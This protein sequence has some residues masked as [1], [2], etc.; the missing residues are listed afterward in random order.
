MSKIS[1]I[2]GFPEFLPDD[3]YFFDQAIQLIGSTFQKFGFERI[4]T[5]AVERTEHL[6]A[7]GIVDKE[8][9]VLQ[10]LH[11][12]AGDKAELALHFDLTVPLA[13]YVAQ[14]NGQLV[15]PF[16]RYQIQPVWRGERPQA[17]RYRQF[18]QCDIDVIGDGALSIRYDAELFAVAQEIFEKLEIGPFVFRINHRKILEA[19]LQGLQVAKEQ[20]QEV[21]KWIDQVEKVPKE[22][23]QSEIEKRIGQIGAVKLFQLLQPS[24]IAEKLQELQKEFSSELL[25][26]GVREIEE[27]FTSA[28]ALGVKK[29]NLQLDLSIARGL[30]YYTGVV[31]ETKA[32]KYPQ[33]GSI[34]SGGRYDNLVGSFLSKP[35]PGVGLSI[36][37]S[38]LLPELMKDKTKQ[39]SPITLLIAQQNPLLFSQYAKIAQEMRNAGIAT[40]LYLENKKF[41]QQIKYADRKKIPYLLFADEGELSKGKVLLKKLATSEQWELSVKEVQELLRK[42]RA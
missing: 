38:R 37:I 12:E 2:S 18:Y 26:E 8:V 20:M 29:E 24:P 22:L 32:Q 42:E 9:Y 13:R 4:E 30:D 7:K 41:P 1:P 36:G 15:F 31:F 39:R 25:Q 34:C 35:F 3:Q 14:H 40:E 19:I 10:R 16:R 27:V 6:L 11:S 5:P 33:L 21:I 17:G 23:F 28:I